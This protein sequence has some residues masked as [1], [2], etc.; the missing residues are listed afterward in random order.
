MRKKRPSWLEFVQPG[1]Y[2]NIDFVRGWHACGHMGG[3]LATSRAN[4]VPLLEIY[5]GTPIHSSLEKIVGWTVLAAV[6]QVLLLKA[7]EKSTELW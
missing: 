7:P 5:I 1:T 2:L 3:L 4:R 6:S